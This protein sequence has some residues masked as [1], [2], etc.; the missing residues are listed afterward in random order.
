MGKVYI[1]VQGAYCTLQWDVTVEEVYGWIWYV[2]WNWKIKKIVC[3]TRHHEVMVMLWEMMRKIGLN[4]TFY[5]LVK[6]KLWAQPKVNG[7]SN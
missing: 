2:M 6:A 3:G 1:M 7:S 4:D 5:E